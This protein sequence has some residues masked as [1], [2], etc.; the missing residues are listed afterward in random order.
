MCLSTLKFIDSYTCVY[1]YT[2]TIDRSLIKLSF[3]MC[4]FVVALPF[5]VCNGG[6]SLLLS[7]GGGV[8]MKLCQIFIKF[9]ILDEVVAK[10]L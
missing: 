5:T 7:F 10:P 6:S 2:T 1:I 4:Y 9:L 3:V 8:T